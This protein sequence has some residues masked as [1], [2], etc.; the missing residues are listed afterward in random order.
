MPSEFDLLR[1]EFRA[2]ITEVQEISDQ[3]RT[4]SASF[5]AEIEVERAQLRAARE[6]ALAEYAEEAREGDA[7]RAREELQRRIDAEETTWHAVM[8][9]ADDHWSAIEVREEV[10]GDARAEVD[11]IELTDPETAE[12]YRAQA[13]LREGQRTGEW[14]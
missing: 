1:E 2:A 7:G 5:L 14:S 10:V 8:S 11:R 9:G 3:L 12:R 4:Q 13:T 6:Q